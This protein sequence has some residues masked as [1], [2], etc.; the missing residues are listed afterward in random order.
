MNDLGTLLL[1]P[2][3]WTVAVAESL[4]AGHL[5]ARI[6]AVSGASRYFLGGV[7]AYTIE[8]KAALLGVDRRAAKRVDGVSADIAEQ[9]AIG[10]CRLFGADFG[11]ATTGYAEP[12][13]G[14]GVASPFAW[15]AVAR[16]RGARKPWVRHGRVECPGATR[17]DV[18]ALVAEA[19]LVELVACVRELRK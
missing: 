19:A 7:T 5:Q 12:A 13:P 11:V 1:G 2:P 18:Q 14:V 3:L 9:M 17:I 16:W 8:Q 6:A 15:W 10:A 4:T